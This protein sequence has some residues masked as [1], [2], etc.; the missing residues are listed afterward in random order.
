MRHHSLS[1]TAFSTV[2]LGAVALL[3]TASGASAQTTQAGCADGEV[4]VVVDFTDLGGDV[5]IGCSS[6]A[7]S[8]TE[9]LRAAGFTDSRDASGLICAI[10]ALPD[11]C[12]ATFTGS[13]WSYWYAEGGAWQTWM[14]GSD[15]AVPAAGGVEGW[16]YNDGSAGPDVDPAALPVADEGQTDTGASAIEPD[17]YRTNPWVFALFAGAILAAALVAGARLLRRRPSAHGPDGQD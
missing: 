5:E 13:Y 4:V 10:D 2:V 15:T 16:R 11:P 14:E 1:R 17:T 9:A 7:A 8:G 3:T 6:E 12:P